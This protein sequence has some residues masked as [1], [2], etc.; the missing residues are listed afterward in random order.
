M[1]DFVKILEQ[2]SGE[3]NDRLLK[4]ARFAELGMSAAAVIHEIR[5]PLTA[6][7]M[8]LQLILENMREGDVDIESSVKDAVKLVSKT[9]MLLERARDF[10]SPTSE[11]ADVD[12]VDCI[13]KVLSA[14]QWQLGSNKKIKL[15]THVP[16]KL[17]A[18]CADRAQ[19]EQMLA[20]LVANGL[21]A[22]TDQD[23]GVVLLS[24]RTD[25]NN[26]EFVVAD[27]GVGMTDTVRARAFEPFFSTK[28]ERNGTGLGLFIVSQIVSRYNGEYRLLDSDELKQLDTENYST[29]VMLRFPVPE[30]KAE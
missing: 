9:E 29:G 12:L 28:G 27:N 23:R 19:I 25:E 14:F 8:S 1:S 7:S 10:M 3:D 15:K 24:A 21:D 16:E 30:A 20:N 6:L 18:I 2:L 26:I 11:V 22:V 4:V 13:T 5:Q 17:P